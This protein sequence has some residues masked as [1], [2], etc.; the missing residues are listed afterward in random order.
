MSRQITAGMQDIDYDHAI[1]LV[2]V[3]QK[4]LP[5]PYIS[6]INRV[7]DQYG[8]ASAGRR[9]LRDGLTARYQFLFIKI[10]LML[11]KLV[12]GPSGNLH[13]ASFSAAC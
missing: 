9:A 10:G 2:Q 1:R 11:S 6:E 4:V 7:L 8:T 3:D 12:D 5:C 13:Q